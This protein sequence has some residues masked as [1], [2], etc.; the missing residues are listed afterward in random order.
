M[1]MVIGRGEDAV[2]C[3]RKNFTRATSGQSNDIALERY[4]KLI[5]PALTYKVGAPP[6]VLF[7]PLTTFWPS[8]LSARIILKN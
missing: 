8:C 7:N 4:Y 1:L 5:D 6:P 3:L 2:F